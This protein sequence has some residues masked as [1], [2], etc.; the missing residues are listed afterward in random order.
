MCYSEELFGRVIVKVGRIKVRQR[1]LRNCLHLGKV[2]SSET[3][4]TESMWRTES[5][6]LF[7]VHSR[8]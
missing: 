3:W 2:A 7:L 6:C 1:H 8:L 5:K 4:R